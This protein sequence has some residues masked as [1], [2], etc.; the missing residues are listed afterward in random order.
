MKLLG[1]WPEYPKNSMTRPKPGTIS[2]P[3]ISSRPIDTKVTDINFHDSYDRITTRASLTVLDITNNFIFPGSTNPHPSS[4]T[5]TPQPA[6]TTSVPCNV[7]FPVPPD[8]TVVRCGQPSDAMPEQTS[9]TIR[10]NYLQPDVRVVGLDK[11]LVG[12]G[13]GHGVTGWSPSSVSG[14]QQPESAT[15]PCQSYGHPTCLSA[16]QSAFSTLV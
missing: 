12:H 2:V 1:R 15:P 5:P 6:S 7:Q 8:P 11:N 4:P 13:G 16:A 10:S 9:F 14:H 3:T